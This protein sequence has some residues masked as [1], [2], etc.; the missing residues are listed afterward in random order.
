MSKLI[1]NLPDGSV[2]ERDLGAD[3]ISIGRAADN[4]L[5]INDASVSGHHAEISGNGAG[6][7]IIDLGSTNGTGINGKTIQEADLNQGDSLVI[8]HVPGQYGDRSAAPAAAGAAAAGAA[9][10][11]GGAAGGGDPPAGEAPAKSA[12]EI[13]AAWDDEDDG[14]DDEASAASAALGLSSQ[15]TFGK[16]E[17][18]KDGLGTLLIALGCLA[19][20]A[21]LLAIAL[22]FINMSAT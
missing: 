5:V 13:S 15:K 16:K 17:S 22:V 9:A 4:D 19:L 20:V 14:D 11:I 8:G 12:A 1:L 7:R 18:K 21:C 10:A 3:K 2:I 6:H